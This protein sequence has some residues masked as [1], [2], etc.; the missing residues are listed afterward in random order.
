MNRLIILFSAFLIGCANH[1]ETQSAQAEMAS[2]PVLS[3]EMKLLEANCYTCH[4]PNSN[5]HDEILAPPLAG[6]K[7]RYSKATSDRDTFIDRMSSFV[8][9]PSEEKAIMKGP[10][11]RFGVMPKPVI[12]KDDIIT[13]VTYIHDNELPKPEWFEGH[14]KDSNH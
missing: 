7:R 4:N 11:N 2:A 14:H 10:I 5:S 1:K 8:E 13:I 12:S 9:N 6:I 3:A